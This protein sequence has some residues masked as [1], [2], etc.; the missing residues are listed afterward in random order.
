VDR[1]DHHRS[2]FVYGSL[3]QDASLMATLGHRS[4]PPGLQPFELAGWERAWNVVS[5][6]TFAPSEDP[7]GPHLRRVVLGLRPAPAA[8]CEG[9]LL[10]LTEAD[11][12]ALAPREAA[13]ELQEVGR[14]GE[15]PGRSVWTFVPRAERMVGAAPVAEPLVVERAYLATC[16]A[17]AA[18]HGLARAAAELDRTLG[19]LPVADAA[20]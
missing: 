18:D 4:E 20:L 19:D 6:R 1:A 17:G 14:V 12:A 13:Y 8:R 16:R 5:A 15:D 10:E 2:V 9:L 11:L 3:L 7:T